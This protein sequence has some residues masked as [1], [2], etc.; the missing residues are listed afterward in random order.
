[1]NL[2]SE[3][4]SAIIS[5]VIASA[6][7]TIL[8]SAIAY[9]ALHANRVRDNF[10][11]DIDGISLQ[12]DIK[13]IISRNELCGEYFVKQNTEF[14]LS[15]KH[16]NIAMPSG[17]VIRNK[18]T[19]DAY[20]LRD[21]SLVVSDVKDIAT[22]SSGDIYYSANVT[23]NLERKN[24]YTP[25][26][27]KSIG[28]LFVETDSSGVVTGCNSTSLFELVKCDDGE[29][30]VSTGKE[31][32]PSC[33]TKEQFIGSMCPAGQ[34]I[35]STGE[36]VSCQNLPAPPAPV[37]HVA[38]GGGGSSPAPATCT[39]S[40]AICNAYKNQLGRLP[41]ATGA[42]YWTAQL[43]DWTAQYGAVEALRKVNE[44]IGASKEA[45]GVTNTA[46]DTAKHNDYAKISNTNVNDNCTG[47][48][49]CGNNGQS[50]AARAVESTYASVLGRSSD[51]AGKA[52]WVGE[53]NKMAA[54]GK[55]Q[56]QI[57]AALENHFKNS[58]EYKGK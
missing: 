21:L 18:T 28:L 7:T 48:T 54:Q 49:G 22:S 8:A 17:D 39:A 27:P 3:S 50:H 58:K 44:S 36:G 14:N 1:M 12:A 34:V 16:I 55:S 38:G 26:R 6:I 4:G 15:S 53:A 40:P 35:V 24:S 32:L 37:I 30:K 29:I 41:D 11:A 47:G 31:S 43:N 46:A 20:S 23:L 5:T 9:Q 25:I 45:R 52:Y 13:K 33:Q 42:D 19:L 56:A 10:K 51:A 2:K 57:K